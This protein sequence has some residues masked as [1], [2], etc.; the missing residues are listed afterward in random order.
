MA[1]DSVFKNLYMKLSVSMTAVLTIFLAALIISLNVFL[2]TSNLRSSNKFMDM[3]AAGGGLGP[4]RCGQFGQR[5][6]GHK[7]A[8]GQQQA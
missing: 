3:I 7:E 2:D 6:A 5:A 4:G 1:S 8:A